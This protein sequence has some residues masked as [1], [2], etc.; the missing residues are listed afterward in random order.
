MS[1]GLREDNL[2]NGKYKYLPL[3]LSTGFSIEKKYWDNDDYSSNETYVRKKGLAL[4]NALDKIKNTSTKQLEIF[5]NEHD[6]LPT[7]S[8]LKD[9]IQAKLGM[10]KNTSKDI[11]I[12]K[13]IAETVRTRTSAEITSAERWSEAT[14]KQYTNLE[15]HIKSYETKTKTIL[16]FAKLTGE[17]FLDFFK[18]INDL[19]KVETDEYYAHNT[20]AKINKHFRAILTAANQENIKIGFNYS[21]RKYDIKKR[22]IKNETVLSIEQ[23]TTIIDTDVSSLKELTHAKNY[24]I[25][26]CFTG[27]RIGDMVFLHELEPTNL[28]HNSKNYFCITTQIRK[29]K[30]NKDDLTAVIPILAPLK[31]FLQKNENVF[32][33][34]PAQVNI[35]KDITKYLKYLKF[36]NLVDVK[37]YYYTINKA[38]VTKERL[39]DVFTPHDCRSTFITNLKELGVLDTDIEPITH[40]KNK[41]TS[42]VQTY[43]KT[44][45]VSKAVNLI[46]VLNTKDCA[47]YK[48]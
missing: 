20:I 13:Y 9:I 46:N 42:I 40:P 21:H 30:E 39:C 11:S 5:E 15:N 17:I 28:K 6:R 3:K 34:F 26:S 45:M 41:S 33:K 48:Y 25:Q 24:I 4:N 14:G 12:A 19:K 44:T 35:R 43:D 18:T 10:K 27:L 2:K 37:K 1:Y 38:V 32:P 23:L 47:L 29:N 7:N 16:S 31:D 36:E 8:E 22:E